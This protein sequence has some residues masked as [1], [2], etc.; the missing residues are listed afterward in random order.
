MT[1]VLEIPEKYI[2]LFG[3][4]RTCLPD[5]KAYSSCHSDVGCDSGISCISDDYLIIS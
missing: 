1:P 3:Y 4:C 5:L 2:S